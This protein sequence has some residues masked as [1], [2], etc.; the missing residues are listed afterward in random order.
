[1]RTKSSP[2]S[3]THTIYIDNIDIK[4]SFRRISS[5]SL[6][7][8]A[9]YIG[10]IRAAVYC[11]DEQQDKYRPWIIQCYLPEFNVIMGHYTNE[12]KCREKCIR[13]ARAY[14]SFLNID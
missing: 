4:I 9:M 13:I 10:K 5:L 8:T 7:C 14:C 11:K 12:A 1:M 6:T 2:K 3:K